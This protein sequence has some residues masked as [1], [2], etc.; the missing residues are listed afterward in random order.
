[1]RDPAGVGVDDGHE[2]AAVEERRVSDRRREDHVRLSWPKV[3][4][5]GSL[6]GNDSRPASS[7][8][9]SSHC[10]RERSARPDGE[11]AR[12]KVCSRDV[13]RRIRPGARADG[14]AW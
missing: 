8:A 9:S 7:I 3:Q 1:V 13:T 2:P 10:M 11:C 12:T 4:V 14:G 5:G 6:A